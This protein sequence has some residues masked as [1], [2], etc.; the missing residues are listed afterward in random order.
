MDTVQ[1]A[2]IL[3]T[4]VS[5][6]KPF[7]P[8]FKGVEEVNREGIKEW[9]SG[10][11]CNS[12]PCL[13]IG[14]FFSV[15]LTCYF[16]VNFRNRRVLWQSSFYVLPTVCVLI[17]FIT[18]LTGDYYFDDSYDE[19]SDNVQW[20]SAINIELFIKSRLWKVVQRIAEFVS[21]EFNYLVRSKFSDQ[22]Y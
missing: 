17:G 1:L 19:D 6:W 22:K 3:V 14:F 5:L 4:L 13:L 21:G 9:P 10:T 18:C 8:Y 12:F 15:L 7:L 16:K 2:Y 20:I 11:S